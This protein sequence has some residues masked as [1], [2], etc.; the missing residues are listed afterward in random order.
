MPFF[1][2]LDKME[3]EVLGTHFNIMAYDN[4]ASTKTTLLEGAI[5]MNYYHVN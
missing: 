1:V 4:E 3:I 2:K 5:K